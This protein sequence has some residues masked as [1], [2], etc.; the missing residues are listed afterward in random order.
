M[1]NS[2]MPSQKRTANF[3]LAAPAIDL[4]ER[5]AQHY[6]VYVANVLEMLSQ[7]CRRGDIGA[8][9]AAFHRWHDNAGATEPWARKTS[10]RFHTVLAECSSAW[11]L[12]QADALE[13]MIYDHARRVLPK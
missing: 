4:V 3:R 1:P 10:E 7:E 5:L 12:S 11:E 9:D 6:G 2:T 8:P 13:W